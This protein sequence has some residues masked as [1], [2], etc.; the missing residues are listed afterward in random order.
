MRDEVRGSVQGV[1]PVRH[2]LPSVPA[3]HQLHNVCLRRAN[4]A[5]I[6]RLRGNF[7]QTDATFVVLRRG[8]EGGLG[9]SP[10]LSLANKNTSPNPF[11]GGFGGFPP[12]KNCYWPQGAFKKK[13][14]D[15]MTVFETG[16]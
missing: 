9:F 13:V 3:Q 10:N 1:R 8:E 6:S 4:P 2:A 12:K 5:S 14:G 15:R 11:L 16:G 7:Y